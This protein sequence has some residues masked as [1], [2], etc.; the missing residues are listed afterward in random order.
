MSKLLT[1][2]SKIKKSGGD[3]FDIWNFGIPAYQSETGIKTC[4]LAGECAKG[5]YAQ[6]GAY[7]WGNV[8]PAFERRLQATLQ[9]DFVQVM[10]A[11]I[12][13]KAK[14]SAAKGK[15]LVVRIHDS[16]DFYSAGYLAKWIEVMEQ[17]QDVLFYAYTKSIPFFRRITTPTNFVVI[18]SEG[19]K[20]DHLIRDN[21]R[22]SRVFES[23]AA[24]EAAGYDDASKDDKVAFLSGS[25]KIGLIY[26]G[27]KSKSWTTEN[28]TRELEV[29]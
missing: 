18:F 6:Q 15:T 12:A 13:G 20:L 22:H 16:G 21:D 5:C 14:R 3:K 10:S 25:G 24:L 7:V 11:E 26:H 8:K 27:A 23:K 29:A 1:Q 17:N 28:E 2:N 9:D 4:P 19:G